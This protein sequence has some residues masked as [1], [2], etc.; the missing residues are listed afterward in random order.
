MATPVWQSSRLYPPGSLVQPQSVVPP[1]STEI[2]NAGFESGS[3]DW[4]LGSGVAITSAE[5]FTGANS[6]GFSGTSG[7]VRVLHA[8]VPCNPGQ[9]I[10]AS[11]YYQQ[12]AASSGQN[13]G[14]VVLRW[15]DAADVLLREDE[16]TLIT[17]SSGG[18]KKS[19]A[20][21]KIAP[22][23][24]AKVV[25]GGLVNR[26]ASQASWMDAF[27]W[28][29][30][31]QSAPS[32]LVYRAV[33][34]VTG[35]SGTDEPTWPLT[36]GLTVVDNEVTW[37]AVLANRVIWEASPIMLSGAVEPVWPTDVGEFIAD[38]T[39]S[40]EVISRRVED[41]KCP[42]SKVVAIM[43]GKVFAG[44]RDIVR[45]SAT[46]NPLDWTTPDD[47]G[48]LP[49]GLQQ[50]NANDVAVLQPYRS[51]LC[52]FNASSF[53]NWQV[54]PDPA[55]MAILDQMEGIGSVWQHA[56]QSVGN[57]LFYLS[58]RGVRTVGIAA[59]AE[60]LAAGDVGMPIDPLIQEAVR[61][62]VANSGGFGIRATY[63]PSS[64][65]YWL[66]F[67][68]FPP[69][70][71][72]LS[73]NLP[74]SIVNLAITPYAYLG[75]GGIAPRT[76]AVIGGALPTG[77]TLSAAG[78]VTG[79]P[80]V[81]GPFS[82]TV[83]VTDSEGSTAVLDDSAI[84]AVAGTACGI[85][86]TYDGGQSFPTELVITLGAGLGTVTLD[87]LSGPNPDRF[88]VLFDGEIVLDTQ[89][90]GDPTL[91]VD[92]TTYQQKLDAY[93]AA[94]SLPQENIVMFN[95]AY[96]PGDTNLDTNP[97]TMHASF[98]KETVSTTAI[99]RVY[100]PLPGTGWQCRLGCPS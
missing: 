53:Q 85:A 52:P 40:W 16:G 41:E 95:P 54:D 94:N 93:M 1:V 35:Y 18:W 38:N 88:V 7:L 29:Y 62:T 36:L 44:D 87:Y 68:D 79:T 31:A 8:S 91:V 60:N 5:K 77:L 46:A 32:G 99:L 67:P 42:N 48:Y 90:V 89:Y 15:L 84:I 43:A 26:T 100:G 57:E 4:T 96:V 61:V 28:D 34:A 20:A 23:N 33:Q 6:A 11:C 58:Q 82:W 30:A 81:V 39:I 27:A 76:Y 3:T 63:Y 73:G 78:E 97:G 51:N 70:E 19:T 50:A 13:I 21:G 92:G 69:G 22:A 24:T 14:R 83:Q 71:L 86:S 72:L 37:E 47:A 64:G 66:A 65:Q 75:S 59:G 80:T 74:D 55:A 45:F 10:T 98:E 25:I 9:A 12:G 17:S 56:A 49:T 2:T